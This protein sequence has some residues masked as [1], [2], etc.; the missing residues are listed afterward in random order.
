M[1][2]I[3]LKDLRFFGRHGVLPE[4]KTLGQKFSVDA[5][6]FVDLRKA[7]ET[8]ELEHTVDYSAVYDII[9]EVM[10]K[11]CCDL[12]E[13]AAQRICTDILAAYPA[14]EELTVT[15]KKP[16]APVAGIFDYFAVEIT[17][18]RDA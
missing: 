16:E 12:I 18:R 3:I 17:R 11:E 15:I 7:G 13:A 4:E 8:D 10:E 6:L 1:D 9:R 5:V 14:V 2:K